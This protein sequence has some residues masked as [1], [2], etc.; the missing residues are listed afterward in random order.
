MPAH[1]SAGSDITNY[2]SMV[3]KWG[4]ICCHPTTPITT[5][6]NPQ[7]DLTNRGSETC[8]PGYYMRPGILPLYL[9]RARTSS[10]HAWAT[11][12]I[13]KMSEKRIC[14]IPMILPGLLL[15]LSLN[16]KM[17]AVNKS[18]ATTPG[19]SPLDRFCIMEYTVVKFMMP[20]LKR[21]CGTI[22][23]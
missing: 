15:N 5:A 2:L 10:K 22:P 18:L 11:D 19:R 6:G 12:G 9:S 16:M 17:V 7:Q 21:G 3:K 20:D 8:P 13:F 14:L 23:A 4:I 1:I